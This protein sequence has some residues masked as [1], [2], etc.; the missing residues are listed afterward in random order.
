ML[1]DDPTCTYCAETAELKLEYG[2][3]RKS[4][5]LRIMNR[6]INKMQSKMSHVPLSDVGAKW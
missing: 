3:N 1:I 6:T 2:D 5:K 4:G